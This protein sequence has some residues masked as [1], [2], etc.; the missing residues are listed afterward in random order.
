MHDVER[1]DVELIEGKTLRDY[2][3]SYGRREKDSQ[4]DGIVEFLGVDRSLLCEIMARDVTEDNLNEFGRFDALKESIDKVRARASF[5][6]A[7][8]LKL[9]PFKVNI[10]AADLL[11]RFV[12]EGGFGIDGY[13]MD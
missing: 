11:R 8:G 7:F 2:I 1:G 10:K 4:F 9:S 5:E 13:R 12:L 3:T 6:S